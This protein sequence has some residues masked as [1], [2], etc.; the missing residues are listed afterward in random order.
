[1]TDSNGPKR[2]SPSQKPTIA[3]K[4]LVMIRLCCLCLFLMLS[5][6]L[7][8]GCAT[9]RLPSPPTAARQDDLT[10]WQEIGAVLWGFFQWGAYGLGGG[11]PS[12]AFAYQ[13][14]AGD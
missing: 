3:R 2:K 8:S 4:A 13:R 7:L 5:P 1:M 10:V 9:A 12:D 11:N 6:S 14:G